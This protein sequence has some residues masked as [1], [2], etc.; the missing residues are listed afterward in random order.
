MFKVEVLLSNPE[1][2]DFRLW[3]FGEISPNFHSIIM[4]YGVFLSIVLRKPN[5][6]VSRMFL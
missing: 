1:S 3:L 6:L 5:L 4:L 2:H